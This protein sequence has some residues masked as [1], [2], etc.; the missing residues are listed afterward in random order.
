MLKRWRVLGEMNLRTA[1][2][3]MGTSAATLSRLERGENPDGKTLAKI[4]QWVLS[5]WKPPKQE[6]EQ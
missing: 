2:K 5:D 6:R 4:L 1:A 3:M